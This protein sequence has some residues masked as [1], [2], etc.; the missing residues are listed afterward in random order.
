MNEAI[1]DIFAQSARMD[2]EFIMSI[3]DGVY[4]AEGFL[5]NDGH[6][7]EPVV[8]KVKVEIRGEHMTIDLTGS[9]PQ[10]QGQTNCG[11]AQTVSACRVAFK[12][13][14]NP[15]SPVT[16]GNFRTLHVIAPE[17]TIFNAKA[18]APCGWYFSALGLLIDLVVKALSPSLKE[19]CAA[20]H[21]G[22]SMVVTFAGVDS[23]TGS[24]F[25]SVE[26]TA[27]GWGGFA[28]HDGQN[29]LINNVNGDF[30]NMPIEIFETKYPIKMTTYA[31]RQDS[32]GAGEKRGGTGVIRG[33]EMRTDSS[34]VYLWFERSKTPAWGLFG[35]KDGAKP[36]V[37]IQSPDG[38][39]VELLKVNAK[40]LKYGTVVT[41]YTGGG[42][43]FGHPFDRDPEQVLQ[44]VKNMYVS[45]EAAKY[46]YGVVIDPD[47]LEL[48]TIA[49]IR[50]RTA[51]QT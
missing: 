7:T 2:R 37:L 26:A 42:G 14:V 27:G 24:P 9:S 20:A 34:Y 6:N 23:K 49:T 50:Y 12:D 10:Q 4:E 44:D 30:K 19:Q 35:G 28:A 33:Y 3:P 51:N 22:D 48:D 46:D 16:G 39:T 25:L 15:H 38:E 45:V 1:E 21:Y 29:G 13:L 11:F 40:P 47:T 8:V 18:P 36:K 17:G 43:G 41:A 32:G 31:L 5:D